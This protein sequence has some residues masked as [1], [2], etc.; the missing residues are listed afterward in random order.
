MHTFQAVRSEEVKEGVSGKKA[1]EEVSGK[2]A[3]EEVSGKKAKEGVS[4]KKAKEEVSGKK[5]KEE[6]LVVFVKEL[7]LVLSQKDKQSQAKV[8]HKAAAGGLTTLVE[9]ILVRGD[10]NML[11]QAKHEGALPFQTALKARKYPTAIALLKD[12]K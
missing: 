9:E 10:R 8:M 1:K 12:K 7:D 11:L 6:D 4:G 2:K 3:K 5:V